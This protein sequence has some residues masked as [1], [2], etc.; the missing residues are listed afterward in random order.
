MVDVNKTL[1][2]E[3]IWDKDVLENTADLIFLDNSVAVLGSKNGKIEKAFYMDLN[4][5]VDISI[6][7]SD[8][9][10]YWEGL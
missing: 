6:V 4:N 8:Y 10:S 2:R 3:L 9:Y 1:R 5:D 7:F